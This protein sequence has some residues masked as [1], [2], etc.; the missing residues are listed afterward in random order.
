MTPSPTIITGPFLRSDSTTITF[1]SGVRSERTALKASPG[2]DGLRHFAPVTGRQHDALDSQTLQIF[3]QHSGSGADL[4]RQHDLAG[5]LA[6]NRHRNN[7]GAGHVG[8]MLE[9]SG[10]RCKS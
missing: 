1:W 10:W 9:A 5:Q 8:L 6:V 2:G 3:Q 4:V 7:D